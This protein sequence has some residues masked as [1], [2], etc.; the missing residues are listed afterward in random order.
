MQPAEDAVADRAEWERTQRQLERDWYTVDESGTA[1][2]HNPFADYVEHDTKHEA[3]L[4]GQQQAL[5]A[6]QKQYNQDND[7]WVATRLAQS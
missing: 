6:R 5:T 4:R 2:T 7:R 3:Q 1:D